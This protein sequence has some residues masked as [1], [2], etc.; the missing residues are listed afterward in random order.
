MKI[1][2]QAL[3]IASS[4]FASVRDDL[5]LLVDLS[6]SDTVA[7]VR[8]SDDTTLAIVIRSPSGPRTRTLSVSSGMR[9]RLVSSARAEGLLDTATAPASAPP[10]TRVDDDQTRNRA[11]FNRV[12]GAMGAGVFYWT[13]GFGMQ[14]SSASTSTG[15]VLLG[16]PASYLGH[17]LYSRDREWTEAHLAGTNYL[18][19]NFYYSTLLALPFLTEFEQ[20]ESWR[21][22]TFASAVA[23]PVGLHLGYKYGER[24]RDDPG[25]VYL[26]QSLANQGAFAGALLLPTL[27]ADHDMG[28][29]NARSLLKLSTIGC[30][31]GEVGGHALGE[32]LF[33]GE[34]VPGGLGLGVSTLANLS[35]ASS[36]ELILD[37][38]GDANMHVFFG[39]LL[40]GNTIGTA[41]ALKTLPQ[42]RDTRER[43]IYISAGTALGVLGGFGLFLLTDPTSTSLREVY[44]W[45]LLGAWAGYGI[46]TVVT[47][48]MVEPPHAKRAAPGRGPIGDIAFAPVVVPVPSERSTRWIWPGMTLTLR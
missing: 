33:R 15:L 29:E 19:S 25:R 45:P 14:P 43:S 18:S 10:A 46:T 9:D 47:R 39:S 30:I 44:T 7:G 6:P 8:R 1:S 38:D 23:Y 3:L 32:R 17:F 37:P 28:E 24:H 36:V 31:G 48:G 20:E 16:Y 22:A 2:L 42:R 21:T 11:M 5:S 41:I 4:A 13:V 27:L 35:L 12:Q 34:P 40:A 26:A